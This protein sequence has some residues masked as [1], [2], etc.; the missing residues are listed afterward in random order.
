MRDFKLPEFFLI[1]S[2]C[3]CRKISPYCSCT[4]VVF[5]FIIPLQNKRAYQPQR[6]SFSRVNTHYKCLWPPNR[7]F[8]FAVRFVVS[9][10]KNISHKTMPPNQRRQLPLMKLQYRRALRN[11]N[12]DKRLQTKAYSV[13][14][15]RIASDRRIF[16]IQLVE[17][18]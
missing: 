4:S 11:L 10:I 6:N 7:L 3:V 16:K 5:R 2:R 9:A 15:G 8:L 1:S 12:G 13:T 17:R 14:T 18:I